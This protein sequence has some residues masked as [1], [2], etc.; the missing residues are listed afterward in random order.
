MKDN[1]AFAPEELRF[2]LCS[3]AFLAMDVCGDHSGGTYTSGALI[4]CAF[5]IFRVW[6][7]K[8]LQRVGGYCPFVA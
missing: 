5:V 3:L 2:L 1:H 6:D 8:L 7:S 4:R